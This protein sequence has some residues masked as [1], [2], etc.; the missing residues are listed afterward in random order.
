MRRGFFAEISMNRTSHALKSARR[1][2]I[3]PFIAMDVKREATLMEQ[4]G[5]TIVHME[6]GEPSAPP[7]RRVRE[8]AI[9]ALGGQRV[10]YTDAL[11]LASLRERISRHY[12]ETYGV[13]VDPARVAV[14]T[15][16]SGGFIMAFLA[17]FD[18]GARVAIQNPGYP[19]YRNIFGALGLEAVDLPVDS[20]NGFAI[21]AAAVEKADEARKLDGLLL[22]SPA[23]PTGAMQSADSLREI[24]EVCDRR[25]IKFI[26]DE[27]Y[28]GLTYDRPAQTAAAFSDR[29]MIVNSFSKY[30]C[31][32]GWRIGWLVAPPEFPRVIERLQ[33]SLAISAP[34]LSQIAAQAAF[35]AKEELEAVKAG[36]RRNRDLLLDGL[37]AL[38][39]D[40]LAPADGAFYIY[41][42]VSRFTDDSTRFCQELLHQAGIAATPGVDFDP[43]RGSRAL[44]LSYAGAE[45]DMIEA[46]KRLKGFLRR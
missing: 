22:M 21:T 44:R 35:D 7:P 42:D 24:A 16:S 3:A 39:L 13:A 28:H 30:Y 14:T 10:G 26:S 31:M 37:P 12:R 46:L 15:G 20:A 4:G 45:A 23:N 43:R 38:G 27:I 29:A 19:A 32:T 41:A 11:G 18:P 33:Q 40:E 25:G 34:T 8:A 6:V 36:Y 5:A 17:L 2:A 1:A 9:A